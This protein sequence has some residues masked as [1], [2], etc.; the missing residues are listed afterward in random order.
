MSATSP[1]PV[2]IEPS[3]ARDLLARLG[4][5]PD[6]RRGGGR[7]HPVGYVL[8]VTV[9]AFTCPA[10]ARLVGAAAWAAAA[11][12]EVLL[13]SGARAEPPT[14]R[15]RPPSEATI[16]R[17]VCGVDPDTL[18]AVFSSWLTA[19]LHARTAGTDD[20]TDDGTAGEGLRGVAVDGKSMR[21]DPRDLLID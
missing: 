9:V 15:V 1:S 8:A 20:G 4:E 17:V 5:I 7:V 14:G 11:S 18:E 2:L 6:P 12:R 10:F 21:G 3:D 16:R 13:M 19:W